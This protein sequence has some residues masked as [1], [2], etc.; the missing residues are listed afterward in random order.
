VRKVQAGVTVVA[1]FGQ[2]RRGSHGKGSVIERKGKIQVG[3]NHAVY[4]MEGDDL[5]VGGTKG[6]GSIKELGGMK[7]IEK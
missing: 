4:A 2:G 7:S 6:L 5:R 3:P 1:M